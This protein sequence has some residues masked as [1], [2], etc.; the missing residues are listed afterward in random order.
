MREYGIF[1]YFFVPCT[2]MV[3]N[4]YDNII[5]MLTDNNE[6]SVSYRTQICRILSCNSKSFMSCFYSNIREKQRF[7][8]MQLDRYNIYKQKVKKHIRYKLFWLDVFKFK[9]HILRMSADA[10]T[11]NISNVLSN[12]HWGGL[13]AVF[14]VRMVTLMPSNNMQFCALELP[15]KRKREERRSQKTRRAQELES[16]KGD[17]KRE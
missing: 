8:A 12:F 3:L 7:F 4:V 2:V 9:K 1:T 10:L 5:A 15:S 14:I 11:W 17:K 6:I 13:V 16:V